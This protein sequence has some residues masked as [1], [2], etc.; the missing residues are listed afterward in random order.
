M[1]S[2]C[3]LCCLSCLSV[4]FVHCGQTV[5]RTKMKLGMQVRLGPGHIVLD[6]ESAPPPSIFGPYLLRP[7]GCVDQDATWYGASPQPRQLCVRWRPRSTL[8][9][10]AAEPPPKFSAHFYCG[11]TA[12]CIKMPL[13]MELGLGAGDFV[14]DGDPASPPPKGHS[15]PPNFRP[16]S[17]AAK[18]LHG[19][20]CH[21]VWS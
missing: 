19:S 5:G 14:L 16:V 4:T 18:W 3:C 21:L 17:V 11:E 7:N 9:K 6:E 13:G 10:K 12:E 8:P 1:L 2:V 15:L 20:R